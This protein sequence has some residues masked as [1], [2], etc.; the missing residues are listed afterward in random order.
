MY[1][2]IT[3]SIIAIATFVPACHS[4]IAV[5]VYCLS[6]RSCTPLS[7]AGSVCECVRWTDSRAASDPLCLVSKSVSLLIDSLLLLSFCFFIFFFSPYPLLV[8][9]LSL[10]RHC[11][12]PAEWIRRRQD[13]PRRGI[14]RSCPQDP[15]VK[16]KGRDNRPPSAESPGTPQQEKVKKDVI[17]VSE[18]A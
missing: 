18:N 4:S 16:G 6:R 2:Y 15:H 17:K 1:L 9:R 5:R 13:V 12:F 10:H 7:L 11:H 3:L 14:L 8:R